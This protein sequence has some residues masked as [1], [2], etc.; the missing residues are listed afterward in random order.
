MEAE[1]AQDVKGAQIRGRE[2]TLAGPQDDS[3][4]V[5]FVADARGSRAH[6]A[7]LREVFGKREVDLLV[8]L[9]GLATHEADIEAA[10]SALT[11]PWHVLALPGDR[12][13]L[14]AHE[15]ACAQLREQAV[16]DGSRVRVVRVGEL[17]VL[18]TVP[19]AP[20]RARLS[21]DAEGCKYTPRDAHD[22]AALF[23]P[24][25]DAI[26]SDDVTVPANDTPNDTPVRVLLSHTPP[27]QRGERA[28]DL[29]VEGVHIGDRALRDAISLAGVALAVHGLLVPQGAPRRGVSALNPTSPVILAAGSADGVADVLHDGKWPPLALVITI[30]AR[31]EARREERRV[32]WT[33]VDK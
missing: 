33:Y 9:G 1:D 10:L 5:A 2:L 14:K 18:I 29:G 15:Q 32:T 22:A 12:E 4:T 27:R 31:R 19:G 24:G 8:S 28:T 3:L 11:G 16:I 6:F 13:A 7:R 21:A 26:P 23:T 25:A 30:E 17:A 20:T